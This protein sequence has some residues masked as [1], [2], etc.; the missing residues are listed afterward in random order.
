MKKRYLFIPLILILI[1]T[2]SSLLLFFNKDRKINKILNSAAYSY[3][4][5]ESKNFIKKAYEETGE[6]ILTEKNK[7]ENIPYLNPA[8]IKYMS[9]SQQAK[10]NVEEIPPT[11][12]FP[13]A[14]T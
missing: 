8:Y 9:L 7:Q 12:G 10:A 14:S 11:Y 2:A 3:L 6:I 5:K 1:L 4:P 13:L